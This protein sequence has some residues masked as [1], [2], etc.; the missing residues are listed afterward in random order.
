M[1]FWNKRNLIELNQCT[2]FWKMSPNLTIMYLTL[3]TL[4]YKHTGKLLSRVRIWVFFSQVVPVLKEGRANCVSKY[5]RYIPQIIM[6]CET[7]QITLNHV[8]QGIQY[9]HRNTAIDRH[10]DI[11]PQ[12]S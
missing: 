12:C 8:Y 1:D 9:S 3:I 2:I 4:F 11:G 10:K 7:S 5:G 6:V